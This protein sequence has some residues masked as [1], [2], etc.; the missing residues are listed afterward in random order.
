MARILLRRQANRNSIKYQNGLHRIGHFSAVVRP[1]NHNDNRSIYRLQSTRFPPLWMMTASATHF[2]RPSKSDVRVANFRCFTDFNHDC[3]DILRKHARARAPVLTALAFDV[4][5]LL[6][7]S[8]ALVAYAYTF[9]RCGSPNGIVC[10]KCNLLVCSY[11]CRLT[12]AAR[13]DE[14]PASKFGR[15]SFV[16]C[17]PLNSQWRVI[18]HKL[19]LK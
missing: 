12:A 18:V 7:C 3:P 13:S 11:V 2:T 1:S 4:C 9:Y 6:P 8:F 10:A 15:I 14:R 16:H 17:I 19:T 5:A